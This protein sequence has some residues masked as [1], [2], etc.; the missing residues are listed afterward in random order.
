[1]GSSEFVIYTTAQTYGLGTILFQ[2]GSQA[3]VEGLT[4]TPEPGSLFLLGTGLLGLGLLARQ[5]LT[6]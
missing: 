3:Y 2:D 6:N 5:K 1:V 4:P